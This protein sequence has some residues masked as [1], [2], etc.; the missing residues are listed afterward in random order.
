[1]L[2]TT[3][4]TI[5]TI[6]DT[7]S[8]YNL[9]NDR[10]IF[11]DGRE[12]SSD[13]PETGEYTELKTSNGVTYYDLGP[14]EI[15][16]DM[17]ES[18]IWF[19]SVPFNS[20][21]VYQI[22]NKRLVKNKTYYIDNFFDYYHEIGGQAF[23]LIS[24]SKIDLSIET[25]DRN[26]SLM[27]KLIDYLF[28]RQLIS[29]DAAI[30]T[31]GKQY[32]FSPK[33]YAFGHDELMTGLELATPQGNKYYDYGDI[34]ILDFDRFA[35]LNTITIFLPYLVDL[36][37]APSGTEEANLYGK[38]QEEIDEICKPYGLYLEFGLSYTI[39]LFPLNY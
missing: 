38:I 26:Q 5:E 19:T 25:H 24:L 31:N 29:E 4:Q 34:D 10:F 30:V 15:L 11:A 6:I 14:V 7:F 17:S 21:F 9:F 27:I 37:Y 8:E 39:E 13:K 12:Y 33:S 3:K 28:E 36:S 20:E 1:M 16:D 2:E 18:N 32:A 35:D 22:I 23:S